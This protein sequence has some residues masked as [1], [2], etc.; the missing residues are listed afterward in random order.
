MKLAIRTVLAVAVFVFAGHFGA[1]A[2]DAPAF[3]KYKNIVDLRFMKENAVIPVK[4]GVLVVDSRPSRKYDAGHIPG[5]V[6]IPDSRFDKMTDMLPEDKGA[7][8]VF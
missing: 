8:L 5:A 7:L 3:E 4:D 1:T 2:A 6:N